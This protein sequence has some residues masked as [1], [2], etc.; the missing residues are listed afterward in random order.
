MQT[1]S[2]AAA[3]RKLG[4]CLVV[5]A[6]LALT[7]VLTIPSAFSADKK[8]APTQVSQDNRDEA[9]R[10]KELLGRA[11]AYYKDK[12]DLALA[13][14]NRQG[15]FTSGDLYVYVVGTNGIFLASGG[16]SFVLIDRVVTNSVDVTGKYF[17]KEMLETAQSKGTGTVEYRWMNRVDHKVE[18][19]V[20]YFEKVGDKI[21]AVGYYIPHAT[22]GQAK[23]LLKKAVEAVK[24]D[25][26]WAFPEFNK[27]DGKFVEDDLYVFVVGLDDGRI[28]AHG[29]NPRLVGSNG[30][31]LLDPSGK[32]IIR[33]MISIVKAKGSGELDYTWRNPVTNKV[34]KK[35][36]YLQKVGDYLVA[37]GYYTK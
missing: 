10:A 20:A 15:E 8:G 16:S 25:Q 9:T 18:R 28:R 4:T 30:L 37:V 1:E 12:K 3:K 13:A 31:A 5:C 35:H 7:S 6:A 33:E 34:E 22:A 19:K 17:F 2:R 27:I 26:V 21:I 23:E 36:S 24:K 32:P 11:V 29:A 14:F